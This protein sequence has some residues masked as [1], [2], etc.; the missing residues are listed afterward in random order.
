[1]KRNHPQ[2]QDLDYFTGIEMPI[3]AKSQ[4]IGLAFK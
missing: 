3:K 1:V 2:K 4:L